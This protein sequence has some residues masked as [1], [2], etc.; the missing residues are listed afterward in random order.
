MGITEKKKQHTITTKQ[1]NN[2]RWQRRSQKYTHMK[3]SARV[4]IHHMLSAS[5]SASSLLARGSPD[6]SS[7]CLLP[8]IWVM[9][10]QYQGEKHL[11]LVF[12]TTKKNKTKQNTQRYTRLTACWRAAHKPFAGHRKD[13]MVQQMPNWLLIWQPWACCRSSSSC[14][15]LANWDVSGFCG[16]RFSKSNLSTWMAILQ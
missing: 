16:G 9:S 13:M 4:V 7:R 2:V 15:W 1:K 14:L 12:L 10:W 8:L 3:P 11:L 6:V 5:V